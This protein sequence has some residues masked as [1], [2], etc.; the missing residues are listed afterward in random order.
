VPRPDAGVRGGRS[1]PARPESEGT[2]GGRAGGAGRCRAPAVDPAMDA[3]IMGG[4]DAILKKH[5]DQVKQ[6]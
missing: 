4:L 6:P 5:M 1:N 3:A 2:G